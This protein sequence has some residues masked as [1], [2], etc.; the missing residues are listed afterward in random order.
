VSSA[1]RSISSGAARLPWN[2]RDNVAEH[3]KYSSD[4]R[5][6]PAMIDALL[7]PDQEL[8]VPPP[9]PAAASRAAIANALPVAVERLHARGGTVVVPEGRLIAALKNEN[10]SIRKSAASALHAVGRATA[11]DPLAAIANDRG[12]EREMRIVA[13]YALGGIRDPRAV[14]ALIAATSDADPAVRGAAIRGL[15]ECRDRR[16]VPVLTAALKSS[17]NRGDAVTALASVGGSSTVPTLLAL[18]DDADGTTRAAAVQALGELRDERAADPLI[19]LLERERAD[20]VR[21]AIGTALLQITHEDRGKEAASW[22]R[23]RTRKRW[24][25]WK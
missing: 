1:S 24:E 15:G 17:S 14:P 13:T 3:L 21:D 25:F 12:A 23:W 7:Q 2:G 18:L 10:R 19:A 4:L 22:K 20:H 8:L 5:A 16:A 6:I 9:E 11:V